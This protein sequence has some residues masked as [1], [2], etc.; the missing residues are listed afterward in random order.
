ML[1]TLLCTLLVAAAGPGERRID[2][3]AGGSIAAAVREARGPL[4]AGTP[5]RIVVEPGVYRESI[6]H[7]VFDA[8]AARTPLVIEGQGVTLSGSDVVT[9]WEDLGGGVFATAWEHDWGNWAYPWE[10]PRVLGH[11]AEMVFV[12]GEPLRQM[13]LEPF[14]Y[15][16]RGDPLLH[17][18]RGQAWTPLPPRGPGALLPWTFGVSEA[19]DR[20]YVRLPAGAD[21]AGHE[22]EVSVRPQAL[23][24]DAG[25]FGAGGKDALTLRGI[26][27]EHFASRTRG[28]GLEGTVALGRGSRGVT[29]DRCRFRWNAAHGLDLRAADVT[30]TDSS[31]THNGFSGIAGGFEAA[32]LSGNVTSFNNWRGAMAGQRSWWLAG[33]KLQDSSDV[34]VED[35]EAVGNLAPGV[36]FDIQNRDVRLTDVLAVGNDGPGVFLELSPG[37][38]VV[39]RLRSSNAEEGL[40]ASIVGELAVRDSVLHSA[41]TAAKRVKEQTAGMPALLWQL[42]E[43]DDTHATDHPRIDAR[44]IEVTG[45]TLIAGP[46]AMFVV[47][48]VGVPRDSTAYSAATA[49]YRGQGNTFVGRGGFAWVP[50]DWSIVRG[51]LE[52]WGR[53]TRETDPRRAGSAQVPRADDAAT[54]EAARVRAFAEGARYGTGD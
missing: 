54:A 28:Y 40:L 42:Y 46:G 24:F 21:V 47:E 14:A 10:T 2:V 12:D 33:V 22:V 39:E 1:I 27:F 25:D 49:A 18:E 16:V 43:R 50:E 51:S 8:A 29:I 52:A 38:F 20:L 35:H 23:R 7:V 36:W 34:A 26:T 19:D 41:G 15:E 31:F 4:S 9:A 11:R 45:T 13:L 6:G 30:I 5:V 44:R 17:A 32:R 53:H 48:N 37:P 3:P